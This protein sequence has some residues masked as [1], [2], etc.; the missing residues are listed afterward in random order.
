MIMSDMYDNAERQKVLDF[1]DY[2]FDGTSILVKKGN[3]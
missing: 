1:V 2:A 3:P